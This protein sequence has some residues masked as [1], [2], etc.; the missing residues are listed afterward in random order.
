MSNSLFFGT[1]VALITPFRQDRSIDFAALEKIIQFNLENGINY[2]V[3]LGT[4]GESVTLS[5][6]EKKEV[7]KFVSKTV[8]G[9]IPLVAGIGG[10]NTE[11]IAEEMRMFNVEGYAA[12]LSVSPYYNKPTQ[13]GIYRH[14]M[15][16]NE[17]APLPI[18]LY[19]VPG[20]TSS[21]ISW[22]TTIR[23]ARAS[24]KFI[25]I[26]EASGNFG[27][28]MQIMKNK[29]DEFLVISGD[30]LITLPLMSIGVAGVISVVAQAVPGPF[31]SMVNAALAGDFNQARKLHLSMVDAM[32]LYFAEGSPAGVKAALHSM[33]LCE[34][35][36]RLPLVPVSETMY[37]K[38][39][40]C[41][42]SG[43][44]G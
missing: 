43:A 17:A 26:K 29:P 42:P 1:G 28:I 7:W 11:K 32:E 5:A 4:T 30:D 12:M 22:E 25:G 18:L 3:V 9:R 27:Q 14:F 23:L 19:N 44:R 16:L 41:L 24:S 10:N 36:L 2:F 21:N 8:A 39:A 20:R 34:N 33:R 13:E 31:S 38:I 37:K 35:E 40:D 15:R 6:Q